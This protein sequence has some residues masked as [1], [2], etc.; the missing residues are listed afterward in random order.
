MYIY[1]YRV[2]TISFINNGIYI[3]LSISYPYKLIAMKFLSSKRHP[4]KKTT[5]EA[6]FCAISTLAWWQPGQVKMMFLQNLNEG[7][8]KKRW[9]NL[10]TLKFCVSMYVLMK[11]W[12][13]AL[14]CGHKQ[15]MKCTWKYICTSLL[16]KKGWFFCRDV[17]SVV[18]WVLRF[19][20]WITEAKSSQLPQGQSVAIGTQLLSLV[21]VKQ[22]S[23]A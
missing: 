20:W 19:S 16:F 1:I 4:K 5:C 17:F 9:N 11:F 7:T 18:I 10:W 8:G 22:N 23:P 2:N 13:C 6:R 14:C 3:G 15:L 21:K 12:R